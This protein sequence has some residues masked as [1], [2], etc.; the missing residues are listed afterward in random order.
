M[1]R[2]K[3]PSTPPSERGQ[4]KLES[5][6]TLK[7]WNPIFQQDESI[8]TRLE[9]IVS[10]K[11]PIL[12]GGATPE[13]ESFERVIQEATSLGWEYQAIAKVISC[14]LGHKETKG[15]SVVLWLRGHRA[16]D[17]EAVCDC[18]ELIPPE[19]LTILRR[20]PK[21]GSQKI[22]F[23]AS[24]GL[25]QKNVILKKLLFPVVNLQREMQS[26][27]LAHEHTN[28]IKTYS[29]RNRTNEVF[30]IEEKLDVVLSD[31]WRSE[32]LEQTALL[33]HDIASAL[34]YLQNRNLVHG[35]VKP[36]NVGLRQGRFVLMDFGVCR[37]ADQFTSEVSATGSLRTRAPELLLEEL[38][39]SWRSDIWA[40]GATV[41]CVTSGNFP[42][43]DPDEGVP[44]V[45]TPD[46]RM[47]F[48]ERLKERVR[49]E[50]AERMEKVL[51][52]LPEDDRIRR[53]VKQ[54]LEREPDKRPRP[55]DIVE[56]IRSLLSYAVPATD[57][58]GRA[59][60]S[61]LEE[62]ECIIAMWSAEG[63][64]GRMHSGR[65]EKIRK[66]LEELEGILSEKTDLR[67]KIKAL[68][69]AASSS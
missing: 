41:G 39:Q 38:P 22:V 23:E 11:T 34:F 45:S 28:I 5:V 67:N 40:L 61:P 14:L 21:K 68:R 66:R 33:I 56:T 9:Q 4:A 31:S 42:L 30:L 1:F 59:T 58:S 12:H 35:D 50:Y 46:Q 16:G 57:A 43:I 60:L 49:K 44:R 36:D 64:V 26:H 6:I 10:E 3:K 65:R 32:G 13:T 47:A 25:Y 55:Q 20:L 17:F 37:P 7:L 15:E 63:A 29:V 53:P 8:R 2:R 48:E 19:D 54:M 27:P 18:I 52:G 62:A 51:Q 24:S 69:E